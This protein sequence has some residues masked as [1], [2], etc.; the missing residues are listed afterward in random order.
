MVFQTVPASTRA[1][2]DR[3]DR[4]TLAMLLAIRQLW[5]QL[6]P[7]GRGWERQ[8]AEDIGPKIYALVLAAQVAATRESNQYVPAVLA[9]LGLAVSVETPQV[10]V[11]VFAG[12]AGDGRPVDTLLAGT[13]GRARAS[14][15]RRRDAATSP[16]TDFGPDGDLVEVAPAPGGFDTDLANQLAL[17]EAESVLQMLAETVVSDTARATETAAMTAQPNV[18]GYYRMLKPPSCSRCVILAGRFYRWNSGFLRHPRCDCVH[19]PAREADFDDLRLDVSAYFDSLTGE[20]QDRTFTAAGAR[21]IRD[22]ADPTRVVNARRGMERAQ[23]GA[24][25]GLLITRESTTRRGSAN[26][27][28]TGRNAVVRLMPESIYD[29]ARDR[30][31]AVRLLRLNG[32]LT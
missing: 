31:D 2:R 6:D 1:H 20:Q 17:Q 4:L 19:I 32:Y 18:D 15:A 12:Y 22:G 16:L 7:N 13:V 30:D 8:Y 28:R 10:P 24:Q 29:V 9:E 27:S 3:L 11:N 23:E 5:R 14:F 25:L 26:R 21:A